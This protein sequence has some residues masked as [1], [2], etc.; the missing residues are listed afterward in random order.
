MTT[1]REHRRRGMENDGPFVSL[2]LVLSR[3]KVWQERALMPSWDQV[4]FLTLCPIWATRRPGDSWAESALVLDLW[5]SEVAQIKIPRLWSLHIFSYTMLRRGRRN[6]KK[7][8]VGSELKELSQIQAVY[9]CVCR[10][11][12]PQYSN[13]KTTGVKP[14]RSQCRGAHGTYVDVVGVD[15]IRAGV[16]QQR[17]E[18]DTMSVIWMANRQLYYYSFIFFDMGSNIDTVHKKTK[19]RIK[20]RR[21]VCSTWPKSPDDKLLWLWFENQWNGGFLFF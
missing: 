8:T 15:I 5:S 13:S 11:F 1:R 2:K 9:V 16:G 12:K 21:N 10:H 4:G 14:S 6:K 18:L 3:L 7:K 17:V 19:C 20:A